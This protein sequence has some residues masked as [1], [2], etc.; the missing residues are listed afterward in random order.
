[1]IKKECW[2]GLATEMLFR[3]IQNRIKTNLP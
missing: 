1:M 3:R 2:K